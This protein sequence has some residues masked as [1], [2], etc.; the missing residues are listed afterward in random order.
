LFLR[1]SHS[2]RADYGG[3]AVRNLPEVLT[4]AAEAAF[5][6]VGRHGVSAA[7]IGSY[8]HWRRPLVPDG[9]QGTAFNRGAPNA[10]AALLPDEPAPE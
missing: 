3:P 10:P 2:P 6:P 1:A 4:R 7:G 9:A 8:F 5:D